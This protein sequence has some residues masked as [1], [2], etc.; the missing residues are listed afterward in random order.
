MKMSKTANVSK[1]KKRLFSNIGFLFILSFSSQILSLV[2][3][4]YQTRVFGPGIFGKVSLAISVAAILKL[5]IDYG[6]LLSATER[7]A[8]K[9][10]DKTGLSRIITEVSIAKLLI[11]IM[12]FIGLNICLYVFDIPFEDRLLYNLYLAAYMVESLMPDYLF[13]GLE[14]MKVITIRTVCIKLFFT[15]M[16]LLT[17]KGPDD[18]LVM[19][20]LL[21]SG[22]IVALCTCVIYVRKKY[23]LYFCPIKPNDVISTIKYSTPFFVSRIASTVYQ[24][25]N[26]V[27]LGIVSANQSIVGFYSAAEK[28]LSLAKSLSSPIADGVYP[29]MVKNRDY[30]LIK[31]ILSI[32]IPVIVVL[33]IIVFIFAS[34]ICAICFGEE[35]YTAGIALRCLMPAIIVILPTYLICFPVMIPMGLSKYANLSTV[36]GAIIQ[37][38]L[39]GCLVLL[40]SLNLYSL[41]IIT[42]ITEV[43]VFLFRLGAILLRKRL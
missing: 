19:P 43:I 6:F 34:E 40:N 10:D 33:A 17:I 29:Y 2:T 15:V 8:K 12:L 7:V 41:C 22:N 5:V 20:I 1:K 35:Y 16:I 42:S 37:I 25:G 32:C 3:I 14:D 21:L 27:I 11:S 4:P 36:V 30:H 28:F 13:R 31:R 24:S 18:Y 9:C 26:T 38:T 23:R 39:L